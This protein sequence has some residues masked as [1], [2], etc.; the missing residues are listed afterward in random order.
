LSFKL[1]SF[2]HL[3][4]L[5]YGRGYGQAATI[6]ILFYSILFYSI[7]MLSPRMVLQCLATDMRTVGIRPR[8]HA[9]GRQSAT[10][11]TVTLTAEVCPK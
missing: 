1:V 5:F 2:L 6:T 4:L 7:V 8:F 3:Y 9:D 10:M 11:L